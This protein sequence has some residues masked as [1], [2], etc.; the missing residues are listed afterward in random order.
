MTLNRRKFLTAAAAAAP[1]TLAL[2]GLSA[3]PALATSGAPTGIPGLYQ[4]QIGQA[5]VTALLDGHLPLSADLFPGLD[6]GWAEKVLN[7]GLYGGLDN[8]SI[9]INGYLIEQAG[10]VVLVDTGAAQNM[11]PGLGAFHKALA[12]AGVS[13]D[14]VDT[15]LLSHL[16]LDHVGGLIDANGQAVFPNAEIV[17]NQAEWNF[18]HDDA[19]MAAAPDSMK[20]FFA[21]ARNSVA[22]YANRVRM[23][24]GEKDLGHGFTSVPMAGHTPGHTGYQLSSGDD[25]LLIWGDM[26]L[27]TAFQFP[28]PNVS[29][30]FDG[31]SQKAAATRRRILDR[32]AADRIWVA[33]MHLDFPALGRVRQ[34]GTA[35][36][37][38]AAPW[39]AAL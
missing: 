16:H 33:G 36:V 9:P 37:Y 23:A 7:D 34:D 29:V 31:D 28:N 25:T 12:A 4:F 22:P 35:F 5:K 24:E 6:Q 14:Q 38:D 15:I 39:Q 10:S 32:A 3:Q 8:M 1:A 19:N 26:I 17:T 2:G 21:I 18:W 20:S 27:S 13:V 30:V 11:G